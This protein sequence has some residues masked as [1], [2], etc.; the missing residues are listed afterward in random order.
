MEG[1]NGNP[2]RDVRFLKPKRKGGFPPWTLEEVQQ[3]ER[4][5]LI[6]TKA[7]LALALILGTGARRSDA[8]LLGKQHIRD[9]WLK[10]TAFKG[11]NKSPVTV[12]F[13]V[14][15]V[16]LD[17]IDASPTGDLTFLVTEFGMPYSHGGF[18]NWF[19]RQCRLAG[20]PKHR[21]AHGLRKVAA[22]WAA[23]NG[24]TEKQLQ[25]I[26][27]WKTMKQAELYTREASRKRLAADAPRLLMRPDHE[28]KSLTLK[29][30]DPLVRGNGAK[31]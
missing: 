11:R 10:F 13:E 1:I 23:E 31:K 29:A 20:L 2:A 22:Q 30:Q 17:T 15:P 25:A 24:A 14:L 18:G 12:E 8:I 26:F 27:G 7:R 3:F 19:R 9:G 16:L 21:S 6:G 4:H 28:Q 5:H